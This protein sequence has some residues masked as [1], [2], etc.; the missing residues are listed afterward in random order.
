MSAGADVGV[1]VGEEL[2]GWA[3]VAGIAGVAGCV[4]DVGVGVG[5]NDPEA[6]LGIKEGVKGI[7]REAIGENG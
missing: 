2:A 7:D 1:G 4:A 5:E 3:G 6:G